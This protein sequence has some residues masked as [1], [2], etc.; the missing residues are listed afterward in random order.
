MVPHSPGGPTL[1]LWHPVGRMKRRAAWILAAVALVAVVIVGLS[2]S[3]ESHGGKGATAQHLTRAEI[4]SRLAGAPPALAALH[5]QSSEILAGGR[6]AF[7]ARLAAL[8][9]HPVVVNFW[10]A[11][12]GP[13][14]VELP[15]IQ[16]ASLTHGKQVAFVGVDLKDNRGDARKLLRS[17]PVAY[18]SYEDPDGRLFQSYGLQGAPTTIFYDA[19]GNK[20]YVHQG[21]YEDRAQIDQDI[22]RYA[23]D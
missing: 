22:E 6:K 18:P 19:R 5:G 20:T 9:G 8:K 3:R 10:A 7:R 13:C 21:P 1:V 23:R 12:C 4:Q 16:Q 17:V 2:Q 14:R 11:W 15:V